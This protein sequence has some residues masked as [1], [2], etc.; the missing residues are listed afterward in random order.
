MVKQLRLV[1]LQYQEKSFLAGN[2]KE[3]L[4]KV[5]ESLG[6]K[7]IRVFNEEE[8]IQRK[9]LITCEGK[10]RIVKKCPQCGKEFLCKKSNQKYCREE[11]QFLACEEK[12]QQKEKLRE[13]KETHP[14]EVREQ[15]RQKWRE[16]YHKR[17]D[18]GYWKEYRKRGK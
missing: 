17:K 18:S 9:K 14:E 16:N 8:M 6:Y 15:Q 12:Y 7:T 5:A 3:D 13:W 1:Y 4:L 2:N 10:L 11:C